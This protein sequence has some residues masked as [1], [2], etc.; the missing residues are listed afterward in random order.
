MYRY[1]ILLFVI[2]THRSSGQELYVFTEAA[3][4]VAAKSFNIKVADYYSTS[5]KLYDRA[6]HRV[7]PQINYG[8]SKKLML[9]TGASFSNVTSNGFKYESVYLYTKYRFFSADGLHKHFRMAAF[10]NGSYSNAPFHF[11]EVTDMG[12]KSGIR[13]G[14]I[15]TQLWNRFSLST[16]LSNTQLLDESR[17][18]KVIFVPPHLY[19][20]FNYSLASGYLVLPKEYKSYKQLNVNLY[21]ELLGQK[22]ISYNKHYLDLAPSL[23]LIAGSNT[24]LNIGHRFQL[25]GN[26]QRMTSSYWLISIDRTFFNIIK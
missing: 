10:I 5:N 14:L 20:S 17:F 18:N 9:Q 12:D 1:F 21:L 15:A 6:A 22:A 7:M 3:S 11:D 24:K 23:Q 26:M 13:I 2:T 19:Q 25:S 16:T 4:N 8:I